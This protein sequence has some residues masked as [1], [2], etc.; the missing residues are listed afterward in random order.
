MNQ[1]IMDYEESIS[2]T[3]RRMF[4]IEQAQRMKCLTSDYRSSFGGGGGAACISQ[5]SSPNVA[6]GHVHKKKKKEYQKKSN[7]VLEKT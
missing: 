2:S 5:L 6:T 1:N 7:F 3:C 4:T